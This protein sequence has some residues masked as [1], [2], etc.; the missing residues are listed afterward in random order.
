MI[1]SRAIGLILWGLLIPTSLLYSQNEFLGFDS[2]N[3][4]FSDQFKTLQIKGNDNPTSAPIIELNTG[5]FAQIRF[6]QLGQGARNLGYRV[7]HCNHNWEKSDLLST[8]FLDGFDENTITDY[9]YSQNTKVQYVHFTFRFPN[10]DAQPLIGGNYLF[11]V[12]D[13]DEPDSVLL[14]AG[15]LILN[16]KV[17]ISARIV[18]ASRVELRESHHE[19]YVN[20]NSASLGAILQPDDYKVIVLQNWRWDNAQKLGTPR[21]FDQNN[22]KYEQPGS[23]VF[24]A[25]NEY[26]QYDLRNI[27]TSGTGIYKTD[28]TGDTNKAYGFVELARRN[29]AY[30][31]HDD[32]N[33][34]S[35]T[36]SDFGFDPYLQADYLWFEYAVK[37]EI[38][39]GAGSIELT[40]ADIESLPAE[41]KELKYFPKQGLYSGR[42]FLKMGFYN[43]QYGARRR[44]G[45]P[46]NLAF[47]E[48][49]YFQTSNYY[50]VLVYYKGFSADF[51]ELVGF[52]TLT[53]Q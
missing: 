8:E 47:I 20:V 52:F 50:Q 13:F 53:S 23:I 19:L 24:Q 31:F 48:G 3:K 1:N 44:K 26:R 51:D 32:L 4:I 11:E 21:F 6:D 5:N 14:Q 35:V 49:S 2:P 43:W 29:T 22:L 45:Q 10:E 34:V 9:Q 37:S 40:G 25:G 7:V 39:Y 15:M 33:G 36:A 18:G 27:N 16:P 46:K 30:T 17:G 28:I 42:A 12:F 38:P 41:Q